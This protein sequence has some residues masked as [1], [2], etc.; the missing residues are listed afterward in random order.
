M[1][2]HR[3]N[4]PP[5]KAF[6][7]SSWFIV[8]TVMIVVGAAG[9][10]GWLLLDDD[11]PS[12]D[13]AAPVVT[14]SAPVTPK[15]AVTSAS[16]EP[17]A[18]PTPADEPAAEREARVS[19]LNNSGI[20]GAAKAFSGKVAAAGWTLSG[21]G[22]WTGS[23]GAN[24]IYYPSGLQDQAKLLAADVE[25]ERIRPSVAPMGMDRLTIIL[26]GPQ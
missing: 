9:W 26:S 20:V 11:P 3:K 14:P 13:E 5:R 23:I 19:V 1:V 15:P 4:V 21:I 24:T 8:L 7:P 16:P 10:L 6:V 2:A 25:I 22:N 18:S 12:S 17:A